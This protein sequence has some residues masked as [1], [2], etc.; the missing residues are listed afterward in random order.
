MLEVQHRKGRK[1]NRVYQEGKALYLEQESGLIRILPQTDRIIRVSYTENGGFASE[2][3]AQLADLSLDGGSF[4]S[5]KEEEKE[6]RVDTGYLRMRIARGTGSISY[7]RADGSLLLAERD[8]ESK[9]VEAFDSYRMV[10]N[11]NTQIEEI[12]TPDGIKRRIREADRVFDKKLYHTRLHLD[13]APEEHLYGLGQAEEG[14]WNLRHTTQYLHQANLKIAVPMLLSDK[15]YGIL[16]STQSPA[17]F[18]DTQ[19][20]TYLYTEA[21]EYLDYYFLAGECAD[22]VTGGFRMLTGKAAMLPRWAFGYIQSQ[23]RYESAVE[24]VETAKRFR[25]EEIPLD[26]LVL[27]WMSWKGNLWGQKTFDGERFP[28]PADMIQKLHEQ[29][30]HF[31]ISIWPNMSELSD[32]YQEFLEK[33][34]FCPP[35]KST[36]P[37][38]RKAAGCTGSRRNGGCSDM[39]WTPGG[40][41]PASRSHRNGED[42]ANRSR[43][44][45][46]GNS[47]R[48][49]ATACP[50]RKATPTDCITPARSMKGSA[51][52]QRKK[53]WLT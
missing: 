20:G 17:I 24:L 39:E 47:W 30:V 6:I 36:M 52:A 40:A 37:F 11:E 43:E 35:V 7:E 22:E 18:N 32:N 34:F 48:L 31:M 26:A 42:G 33:A 44:K 13:F 53:E 12:Q 3:G 19:Y 50:S 23:E 21:D 1:I 5:W 14:V 8:R 25:Q 41:T 45:C 46:T 9:C 27:D 15:G 16:L 51:P 2:Q 49:L 28:D 4:W 29:K 10:V 38:P